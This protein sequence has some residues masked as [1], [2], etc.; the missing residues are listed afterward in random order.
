MFIGDFL[1][2]ALCDNVCTIEAIGL[3]TW[4]CVIKLDKTGGL[5]AFC[6]SSV[7]LSGL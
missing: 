2:R 4:F 7:H 1:N 3:S 5:T 6:T